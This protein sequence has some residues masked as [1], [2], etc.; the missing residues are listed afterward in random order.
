M[1]TYQFLKFDSIDR[2]N[3]WLAKYHESI[4]LDSYQ[5]VNPN[6]YIIQVH[7]GMLADDKE[8][9]KKAMNDR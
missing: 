9:L 1:V 2:L 5:V 6:C 3:E 7:L 8:L 4:V